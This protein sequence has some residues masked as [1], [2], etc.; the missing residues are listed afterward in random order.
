M[1]F[2]FP[3]PAEFNKSSK[4]ERFLEFI[5]NL[6]LIFDRDGVL[7]NFFCDLRASNLIV[8]PLEPTCPAADYVLIGIILSFEGVRKGVWYLETAAETI[9]LLSKLLTVPVPL[10]SLGS[11]LRSLFIIIY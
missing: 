8:P 7:V 1:D 2:K 5:L 3:P 6:T 4:G 11:I 9:L 10:S